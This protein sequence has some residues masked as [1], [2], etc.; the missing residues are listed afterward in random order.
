MGTPEPAAVCLRRLLDGGH[1]VKAIYTQPDRPAGRGNKVAFSP[2]KELG[3][4]RGIEV[5]Q[6]A[7][8]KTEQ[9]AEEFRALD[10]DV[11]VVVAYGRI[12]P[13][14]FLNAFEFGAVNVHFSLLP[15]YRGAAPVNWAIVNGETRTGVTTIKM[16]AGLDTGDILLVKETPIGDTET[17]VELMERLSYIG[18]DVLSE[19]IAQLGNIEPRPQDHSA[20]TLAPLMKRE[21][22]LIDWSMPAKMIFD[23]IR[24]FQP[25]PGTYTSIR[26]ARLGIHKAS[27]ASSAESN[28]PG[29]IVVAHGDELAVACG[30][31]T[32][33][34]I[35]ELQTEGKRRT[36]ARDFINGIHPVIGEIF[37]VSSDKE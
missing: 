32:V 6:P 4:E 2:V 8:I 5:R 27:H 17:A 34:V 30:S 1:D 3:I 13:E 20:A 15:K 11:A 35:R 29:M 14:A 19:T 31:G 18:A 28:T 16:D 23:R 33:L 26:G 24:G 10:A 21:D 12:L 25:F 9:A 36:D 22:G 7:K 37:G